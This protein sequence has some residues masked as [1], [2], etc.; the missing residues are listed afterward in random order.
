MGKVD[1]LKNSDKIEGKNVFS[2]SDKKRIGKSIY[3]IKRHFSGKRD[4]REAVYAT[5]KNE[6]FRT[7]EET[8]K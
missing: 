1:S 8:G 3:I 5:V 7:S 2:L 4:L 6:A